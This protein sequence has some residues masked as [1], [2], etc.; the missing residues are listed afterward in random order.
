MDN[1]VTLKEEIFIRVLTAM[2]NNPAVI[3]QGAR[4]NEGLTITAADI[5]NKAMAI[6]D[7]NFEV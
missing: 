7:K 1:P 3:Q 4:T 6:M 2:V 5:T